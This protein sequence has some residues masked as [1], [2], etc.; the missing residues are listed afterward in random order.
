[1]GSSNHNNDMQKL[2]EESLAVKH[3]DDS[4]KSYDEK[5]R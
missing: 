4:L 3:L 5:L 1:M 2:K